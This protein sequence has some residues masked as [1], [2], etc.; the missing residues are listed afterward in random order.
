MK[1]IRIFILLSAIIALHS[2]KK[3]KVLPQYNIPNGDFENWTDY[4]DLQSWIT[5]NS[6]FYCANPVLSIVVQQ[7]SEASHGQYAAKFIR[8]IRIATANN[9]FAISN[10]PSN[11]TGYV[12]CQLIANDTVLIRIRLF[13]NNSAIDSGQWIGTSSILKY[14]QLSIPIT[15]N[16]LYADSALISIKGGNKMD[17]GLGVSILWIDYLSLH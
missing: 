16:S 7:T 14:K 2:C 11:L 10:H 13:N 3:E 9:K 12:K 4:G 17:T 8:G 15:H 1:I 6:C 5:D